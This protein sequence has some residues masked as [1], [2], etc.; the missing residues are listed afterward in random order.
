MAKASSTSNPPFA[1]PSWPADKI[2]RWPTSKLFGYGRNARVHSDDQIGQIAASIREWGW[3]MP[4]LVDESGVVIAGHGRLSAA[5]R[6]GITEIPVIIARGWT[7][8]QKRAYRLADNQLPMNATWNVDLLKV[9]LGDL[10]KLDFPLQLIGFDDV[11]LV[12]FVSGLGEM[13]LAPPPG[14]GTGSLAEQ[15]GVPPFSVLNAREGWWQARKAAWIA[16]GIQSELG[17]GD[18]P[19]TSG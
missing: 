13:T 4:V 16:L 15:F 9:E 17:R 3:T 14:R 7:E 12:S 2:E 5:E 6:L 1:V 18:T 11:E 10:A 19:S 8:A